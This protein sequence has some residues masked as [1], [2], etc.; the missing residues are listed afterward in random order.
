MT[1][2][3]RAYVFDLDGTLV[4][5]LPD[6]AGALNE[7]LTL[8]GLPTH[9]VDRYR[10]M[11]GEGIPR[12]CERAVGGTHPHLVARLAE[13]GRA[14]YRT[15]LL[16]DTRAYPGVEALIQRLAARGA[17]L[18][19]LSNKPDDMTRRMV[20]Q[21]WPGGEFHAVVGYRHEQGRKPDPAGLL[22]I[23]QALGVAPDE[24]WMIGDTPTDVETARR[25]GAVAVGVTW[26]FRTREELAAAGAQRIVDAPEELG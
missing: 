6:I 14:R 17:G 18:A 3:P 11:V 22:E 26:G 24:T 21:L 13:L 12:L 25:A 7:C 16:R 19:V 20:A 23:C 15:R 2:T 8:L 10:Y 4:N 9:P 5:S 1:D